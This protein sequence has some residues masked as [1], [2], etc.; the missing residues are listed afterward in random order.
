MFFITLKIPEADVTAAERV[1]LSC[2]LVESAATAQATAAPIE[3][4]TPVA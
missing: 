2:S 1:F 4:N 3:P